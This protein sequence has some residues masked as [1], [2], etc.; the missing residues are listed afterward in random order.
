MLR[1]LSA[2]LC[3]LFTISL[4]ILADNETFVQDGVTYTIDANNTDVYVTNGDYTGSVTIPSFVTYNA[5]DYSVSFID[6]QAF[7]NKDVKCINITGTLNLGSE[8]FNNCSVKYLSLGSANNGGINSLQA[9]KLKYLSLNNKQTKIVNTLF[10]TTGLTV[11]TLI[12]DG[13]EASSI[14]TLPDGVK[15]IKVP[16]ANAA[17][18]QTK[19]GSASVSVVPFNVLN[20]S[21]GNENKFCSFVAGEKLDFTDVTDVEAYTASNE[22]I[23]GMTNRLELTRV[24]GP[25]KKNTALFLLPKV[26]GQITIPT[27]DAV[28]GGESNGTKPIDGQTAKS[29][30]V[31]E[32]ENIWAISASDRLLHPV[33]AGSVLP[34]GV[35][36]VNIP[37]TASANVN[38]NGISLFVPEITD[39]TS[40]EA[41]DEDE[42][43]IIHYNIAGAR[44]SAD[45]PGL[46]ILSNGQKV[47]K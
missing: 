41:D 35:A 46:H 28:I 29:R 38:L 16:S 42:S 21:E 5:T 15:T 25:V 40:T 36:Y 39:V 45:A 30:Y 10:N 22:A 18:Y 44:I 23:T 31:K 34:P 20:V 19:F 2:A 4:N 33:K 13:I 9:C 3:L 1:K 11:E 12:I 32:G 26:S 43:L 14:T 37:P 7:M 17:A 24:T 27:T 8:C 6:A 47:Q